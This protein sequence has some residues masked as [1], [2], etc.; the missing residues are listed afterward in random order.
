MFDRLWLSK[1]LSELFESWHYN[2][3]AKERSI[4]LVKCLCLNPDLWKLQLN[5]DNNKKLKREKAPSKKN[6][7]QADKTISDENDIKIELNLL[8]KLFDSFVV[9]NYL[10]YNEY[11]GIFY[12]SKERFESLLDWIFTLNSIQL[13]N[14]IFENEPVP[15][16]KQ[17]KKDK[18]TE[19]DAQKKLRVK[20][21][22]EVIN[23]FEFF[24][25]LKAASEAAGYKVEDFLNSFES[26]QK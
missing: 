16:I 10:N 13:V 15:K 23:D 1:K 9:R 2:H 18:V 4:L 17:M 19:K 8:N 14:E 26:K 6:Q 22:T 24:A 25:K 7:L 12:Y 3:E 11:D 20:F 5:N 21:L